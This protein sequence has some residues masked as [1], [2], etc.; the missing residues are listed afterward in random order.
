MPSSQNARLRKELLN[1]NKRFAI[2]QA[3]KIVDQLRDPSQKDDRIN[4]GDRFHNTFFYEICPLLSIC[5]HIGNEESRIA[6]TGHTERFDGLIFLSGKP[7]PRKI[8]M[9]CAIDGYNDALQMELLK[10]QGHAPA[11]QKIQASGTKQKKRKFH[12]KEALA[13]CSD[14][15]YRETLLP[16]MQRALE[17]KTAKA[18][19]NPHYAGS[20]LGIVFDDWVQPIP[21]RKKECFDPLCRQVLGDDPERHAPFSRVFF[22]GI[23][24]EYLFD[25]C[26]A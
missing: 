5:K 1:P 25:S 12:K 26:E 6:F 19:N 17:D 4:F 15:Y 14:T 8:E 22:V 2:S 20:W 24:R 23:S 9:V 21:E 3:E 18:P 10:K 11:F 13:I 16:L 7:E